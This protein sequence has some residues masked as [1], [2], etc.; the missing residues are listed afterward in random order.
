MT[1]F[2]VKYKKLQLIKKAKKNRRWKKSKLFKCQYMSED[3]LYVNEMYIIE[4]HVFVFFPYLNV[5]PLPVSHARSQMCFGHISLMSLTAEY[6]SNPV[7][8][9]LQEKVSAVP[10]GCTSRIQDGADEDLLSEQRRLGLS[11][12]PSI[13]SPT[14]PDQVVL[15]ALVKLKLEAAETQSS[16]F[17]L[18]LI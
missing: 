8:E 4:A 10:D 6:F 2:K 7:T 18:I 5:F 16:D 17:Y 11:A 1:Q 14:D 3:A 12:A 9:M 15:A 13:P